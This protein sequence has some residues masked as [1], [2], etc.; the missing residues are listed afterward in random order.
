MLRKLARAVFPPGYTFLT[1]QALATFIVLWEAAAWIWPSWPSLSQK[2][3]PLLWHDLADPGFRAALAGSA[4]RMAIGY[5][6]VILIGIGGG[7]VLGR[8]PL[9]DQLLGSFAVAIHAIPG[10]A[11]VPL[12]IL[13]FGMT[14]RA[15]IFTVLLGAG[16]IT[17]RR[18]L[19]QGRRKTRGRRNPSDQHGPGRDQRRI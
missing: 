15:V 13:W 8:V 1:W 9:L 7:I 12:S 18:G 10:A 16:G 6:L 19:G 3:V 11:W 14:E 2:V 4:R 5:S 17:G